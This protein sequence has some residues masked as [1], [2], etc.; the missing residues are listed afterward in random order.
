MLL[1]VVVISVAVCQYCLAAL[2]NSGASDVLTVGA[3]LRGAT[4]PLIDDLMNV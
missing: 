2:T 1:N 4:I 3:V